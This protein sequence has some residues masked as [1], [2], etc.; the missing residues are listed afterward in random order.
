MFIGY[1]K[2]PQIIHT[3]TENIIKSKRIK[4]SKLWKQLRKA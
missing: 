1:N 2:V 3:N 4:T